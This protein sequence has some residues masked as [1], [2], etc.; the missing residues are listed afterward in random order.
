MVLPAKFDENIPS[1]IIFVYLW[2]L[3]HILHGS[4]KIGTLWDLCHKIFFCTLTKGVIDG[5]VSS[6]LMEA[7]PLK[8]FLSIYGL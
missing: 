5:T 8:F 2:S 6:N 4:I 7:H 1:K 3:A